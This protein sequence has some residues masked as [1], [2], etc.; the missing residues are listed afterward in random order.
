MLHI[1]NSSE[2]IHFR[3][4]TISCKFKAYGCLCAV[5]ASRPGLRT[6][7]GSCKTSQEGPWLYM[8]Q[9]ANMSQHEVKAIY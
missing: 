9:K 1:Q 7:R 6:L 5:D 8:G 4:Q 3:L 2:K